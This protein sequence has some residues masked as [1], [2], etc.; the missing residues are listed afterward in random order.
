LG[1]A[2]NL[3]LKE[4]IHHQLYMFHMASFIPFGLSPFRCVDLTF[5]AFSTQIH[6]GAPLDASAANGLQLALQGLLSLHY[7]ERIHVGAA[8]GFDQTLVI[9]VGKFHAYKKGYPHYPS[10]AVW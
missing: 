3:S 7:V 1:G 4:A 8:V 10:V 9:C 2:T 5:L 6:K